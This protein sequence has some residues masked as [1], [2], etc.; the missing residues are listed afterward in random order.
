MTIFLVECSGGEYDDSW[1]CIEDCFASKELADE[2]IRTKKN[3][4]KNVQSKK[5]EFNRM[6]DA[7]CEEIFADGMP[8]CGYYFDVYGASFEDFIKKIESYKE[9]NSIIKDFFI[10]FN[11]E[12]IKQMYDWYITND[13]RSATRSCNIN[14][15]VHPMHVSDK[16]EL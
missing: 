9:R 16:V 11:M 10:K 13:M 1:S 4:N 7:F 14:Y 5:E 12:F 15:W 3:I 6:F 8:E 2:Y